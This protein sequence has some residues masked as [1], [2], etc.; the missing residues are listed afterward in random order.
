M[1]NSSV[2]V[3]VDN[4]TLAFKK[5]VIFKDADFSLPAGRIGGIVGS[6]GCGKTTLIRLIMGVLLPQNGS[7]R[8]F[9]EDVLLNARRRENVSMLAD[10]NRC[11][12]WD[13]SGRE[14]I[15]YFAV[16]KSKNGVPNKENIARLISQFGAADFVDT[17]V[18][19]ISK[20]M[21][22]KI[23]LI[24][25]LL[26]SPKLL[27]LDEPINGLDYQSVQTL[28]DS[29]RTL[30][31]GGLS[32][33][34]TSHDR[35]F[36]DE[37]CDCQYLIRDHGISVL[38]ETEYAGERKMRYYV[39]LTESVVPQYLEMGAAVADA[40]KGVYSVDVGLNNSAFF[41]SIGGDIERGDCNV[42]A[43]IEPGQLAVG[44]DLPVA[45]ADKARIQIKVGSAR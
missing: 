30:R 44:A 2:A 19:K 22:Q 26:S 45:A 8:V 38:S 40:Q 35:Y 33:L 3:Q 1:Q 29:L 6:N 37:M 20:G 5:N 17:P 36:L 11:L 25:A 28:K 10:G 31:N 24:I 14:N 7:V 42:V 32:V 21:K 16:L 4:L 13:I 9:G 18:S 34:M 43:V 12:Y 41:T 27:I 39:R 15:E 23:M